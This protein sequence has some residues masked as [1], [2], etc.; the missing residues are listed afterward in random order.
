MDNT[1]VECFGKIED[2]RIER[3]KKHNLLDIIAISICAVIGGAEGWEEIE[4]FGIDHYDWFSG[5]LELPNGIPSHDTIGRVFSLLKP[6][7]F[8]EAT[9]QWLACI[10]ELLPETVIAIDGKALRGSAR[11]RAELGGLHI[12][13]VWSCSNGIVLGQLKV[14]DKSNE[15]RAV[16]EILKKLF[17][18][19]ATVT[20]D[21]MGCQED[22]I[23][24][25]CEAGADYVISLKGNQGQLYEAVQD[26]FKLVD[27]GAIS[28]QMTH[29]V[30]EPDKKHGRIEERKIEV[31]DT[32]PFEKLIDPRWVSLNS[33][34]R[35]TYSRQ[36]AGKHITEQRYYISSISCSVPQRILHASRSHWQVENNLHWSLD[37]TFSEDVCRIRD[38][39]AALNFSWL[40][41]CAL[42]LLKRDKTF[43]A[44]IRRKQRR[45]ATSTTYLS[46]VIT[47]N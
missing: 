36:E 40:R 3:A 16:P 31:L 33:I 34:A 20:L 12:V 23:R 41:K 21:A 13:N 19:G 1:F 44:S 43:K 46:A 37:V 42:G 30:D 28:A 47:G 15:I 2:P 24:E 38:E 35:L 18:K 4:D 6:S 7:A 45:A 17:L 8:E 25:I 27:G 14:D 22:T 10:K 32:Q 5:F 11:K 29:A 9:L 26:S 39:N